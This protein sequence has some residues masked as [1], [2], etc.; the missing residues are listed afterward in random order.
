M[1]Y[2]KYRPKTITDLDNSA[3]REVMSNILSASKLPHAFLFTGQKGTGKTST[4][5]ILAKS[6]NC[7]NKKGFE[8]CNECANCL[9][10]ENGSSPDV[11]ELDAA[12]NRG[13]DEV[14]NL[15]KESAFSPMTGQYRVFIIDE[16]H[17]ITNDAFN[18]LLK[19]LEEPPKNVI[20]VLATTNEEKVPKTIISRCVR[21]SFGKAQ[22][23]DIADQLKKIAVKEKI[24]LD[25]EVIQLI[26]SHSEA[27]FRDAIKI[28]DELIT[29]KKLSVQD[30]T[31][32]LGSQS[33]QG[34]LELLDSGTLG[35]SLKWL[36]T[37][38]EQGGS[39]KF[40]IESM[41][42]ELREQMLLQHGIGDAEDKTLKLSTSQIVLLL[43]LLQE[44]YTTMKFAPIEAIPLEIALTEYY[45]KKKL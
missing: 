2:L 28:L 29:Q 3:V 43:K 21:V 27:S 23:K 1:L 11:L 40:L 8:P 5:R 9:S 26:I 30:A 42:E 35:D 6:V 36:N 41:L 32:Y 13:I 7:L 39:V 17:M 24:S 14:R 18:A 19:T 31:Q 16:A 22:K 44:A 10:I 45:N 33:K 20:F 37:F 38:T 12:S 34:L 15:I 25:N 4:A